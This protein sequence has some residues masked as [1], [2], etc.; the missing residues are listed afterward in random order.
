MTP[1]QALIAS[2]ERRAQELRET[3]ERKAA[4]CTARIAELEA[5]S[6]KTK[7]QLHDIAFFSQRIDGRL[8][9][10]YEK[11]WNDAV[12]VMTERAQT[13]LAAQGIDADTFVDE[14]MSL[15]AENAQLRSRNDREAL[16]AQLE[17]EIRELL[18]VINRDGGQKADEYPT[19]QAAM[20]AAQ[21]VVTREYLRTVDENERLKRYA[22][23]IHFLA[24]NPPSAT[25]EEKDEV[26]AL[27]VY[28]VLAMIRRGGSDITEEDR[29]EGW[30]LFCEKIIEVMK[31][32]EGL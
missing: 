31:E 6:E 13:Y 18:A 26:I 32:S 21:E 3:Y 20:R 22:P 25:W 16:S 9:P 24:L 30:L 23:V 15:R 19:L 5:D 28:M 4:E 1:E 29:I 27:E 10:E 11:G 12:S 17:G 7:Q 14:N 8:A 2:L